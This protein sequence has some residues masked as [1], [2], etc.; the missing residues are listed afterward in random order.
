M[1]GLEHERQG[2]M[3]YTCA[4]WRAMAIKVVYASEKK[5]TY[6]ATQDLSDGS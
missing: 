6:T 5:N 1:M 3:Y 4:V 2:W